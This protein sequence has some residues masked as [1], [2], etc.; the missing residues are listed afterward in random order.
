[1]AKGAL[2]SLPDRL[3]DPMLA[4]LKDGVNADVAAIVGALVTPPGDSRAAILNCARRP[5]A[6]PMEGNGYTPALHCYRIRHKMRLFTVI[7]IDHVYTLQF[8]YVTPACGKDL[9][10]DRW[11]VL[12][13]VWRSIVEM[14][15]AGKHPA[16]AGGADVLEAAG[17]ISVDYASA[18]KSEAFFG[19]TPSPFPG[20][21]AQV[22]VV[23]RD[24]PKEDTSGL[25]DAL[26][27][28][29]RIYVDTPDLSG[30]PDVVARA[31][32]EAGVAESPPD[33][34]NFPIP[35]DWSL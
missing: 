9:L 5:F 26:S 20:F 22:D 10:D 8:Q 19:D 14:L 24:L 29:A 17:V 34:R 18:L 16:H 33:G 12:D 1:M 21:L 15:K 13:V 4:L 30:D 25:P 27:F 2:E 7:H 23:W 3:I 28:D 35:D 32:T 31:V 6:L 11:A